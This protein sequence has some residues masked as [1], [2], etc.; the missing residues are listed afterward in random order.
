[1]LSLAFAFALIWLS[2]SL[3]RRKR[4]A[5]QL[6]VALVVASA[7]AHLAKGLDFEEAAGSLALL[8]ALLRYRHAFDRPGD[9]ETIRPLAQVGLAGAA[10]AGL[11]VLASY[12]TFV[13]SDRI[14]DALAVVAAGLGVRALYLWLRPLASRVQQTTRERA[15]AEAVVRKRG[16][17]S[18]SY[19]ALRRDK[20]YFFSPSGRSLLA[21]RVVGGAALVSGDPIGDPTELPALVAEFH[22]LAQASGWR[23]GVLGCGHDQLPLY[24]AAGLKS[25]YL[26]DE[27]VVRPES[28]SLEGRRIRKVRQSVSRLERA[29]FRVELLRAADAGEPLRREIAAVAVVCR[30]RWP[31]RGFTMAMDDLFAYDD[32][33]LAVASDSAGRVGAFIQ[34]VPS[35]ASG[36]YSL[37]TM[38]RRRDTP[39]GL[40][41]FLIVR[42]IEWAAC[43]RVPE[44]SLNFAVFGNVLRAGSGAT[45]AKRAFR[46]VLLHLDR[47]FQLERLHTFSRK[48]APEWRPRYVCFERWLDFPIVGLGY[49]HAESLLTPPRPWIRDEVPA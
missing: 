19:F 18:L 42:T 27:A 33:V 40:M 29:G 41:E 45:R 49:L 7:I 39:N 5:W 12:D 46:L 6:A 43:E 13:Y 4:R 34:L 10:V 21:Y 8:G 44:L 32:A 20:S 31:E 48:F 37:A 38:R 3:S 24:E 26:G 36:G 23:L 9:P 47:F 25:V 16:R 35:P 11:L 2:R 1:M 28:F 17:D 14:E 22:R 15:L 30:G